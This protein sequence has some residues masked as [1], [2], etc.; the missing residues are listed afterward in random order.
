MLNLAESLV[1]AASLIQSLTTDSKSF[2]ILNAIKFLLIAVDS[3]SDQRPLTNMTAPQA[4]QRANK[5]DMSTDISSLLSS[6]PSSPL[7]PFSQF[8]D[9]ILSEPG[10][11]LAHS[12]PPA[13]HRHASTRARVMRRHRYFH[14]ALAS[15]TQ[16]TVRTLDAVRLWLS[17]HPHRRRRELSHPGSPGACTRHTCA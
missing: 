4:A 9:L 7:T 2:C 3:S 17:A 15:P 11:P 12:S 1:Q 10:T 16:Y 14:A 6:L 13:S 5:A 8:E